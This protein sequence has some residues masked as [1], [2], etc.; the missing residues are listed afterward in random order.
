VAKFLFHSQL[1]QPLIFKG[2]KLVRSSLEDGSKVKFDLEE[3]EEQA[4]NKTWWRE[5]WHGIVLVV[6]TVLFWGGLA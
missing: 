4:E 6:W 3:E 1:A 5:A 2:N